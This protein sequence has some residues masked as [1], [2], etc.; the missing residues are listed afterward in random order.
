MQVKLVCAGIIEGQGVERVEG[1]IDPQTAVGLTGG[2]G[3]EREG[4]KVDGVGE[5]IV[6]ERC[7]DGGG[8]RFDR[9]GEGK[10]DSDGGEG[11]GGKRCVVGAGRYQ[12]APQP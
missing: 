4:A 1:E 3:V 9:G 12:P 11:E 8:Q 7:R 10:E 5:I 2:Q 6:E